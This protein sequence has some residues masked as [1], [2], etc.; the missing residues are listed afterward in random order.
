MF[1]ARHKGDFK[2]LRF[3]HALFIQAEDYPAALLCLD[4]IF[5]STLPLQGTTII[6][7]GP[8]LL[9]HFA[10]FQLLDRLR[11]EDCLDPGSMRQK[12]FAFQSR[13]DDRF[14]IPAKG[15]LHK[16][17]ALRL[18]TVQEQGGCVVTHDELRRVL[19]Q[20]IPE[21]IHLRAKQ[22]H[23]AYHRKLGSVPCVTMVTVGEC[24]RKDCQFQH[25][26][27]E[28]MTTSWF[29]ARIRSVLL[30]IRIL[31]LAGFHPKG[32]IMCALPPSMPIPYSD[33]TRIATGL[34]SS[35]PSC[36][37]LH[38][39]WDPSRYSISGMHLDQWRGFAFC[40]NGSCKGV[41]NYFSAPE[42]HHSSTLKPS[43]PTSCP[44]ARW[45]TTSTMSKPES[46]SLVRVCTDPGSGLCASPD[47]GQERRATLL[48]G[49]SL[50]F[51]RATSATHWNQEFCI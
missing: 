47:Q 14:F 15:F 40:G 38:R 17:F 29:N 27:P 49:I 16:I 30:E 3:L 34:V 41:A 24:P 39:S 32:V 7:P 21:Y 44:F 31:N 37:H 19:D 50:S 35:T 48:S 25:T 46:M 28:E 4:L 26:R 8:D 12:V 33:R 18:E 23:N 36:I 10:Y 22:Q 1:R 9:L 45:H 51:C 11:R 20:E 2:P 42:L 43:S 6:D 13:E 5:P